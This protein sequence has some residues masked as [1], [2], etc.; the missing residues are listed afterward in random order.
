MARS[1]DG[2]NRTAHNSTCGEHGARPGL[3]AEHG[4]AFWIEVGSK[5]ILF[6][7]GQSGLLRHNAGHLGS[8]SGRQMPSC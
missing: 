2:M 6:D 8:T 4:L 5:R 7:C 3:L 1:H